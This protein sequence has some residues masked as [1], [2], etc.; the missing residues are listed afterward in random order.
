[1]EGALLGEPGK[2]ARVDAHRGVRACGDG[3]GARAVARNRLQGADRAEGERYR[4][5]CAGV[6]SAARARRDAARSAGATRVWLPRLAAARRGVLRRRAL[7][8]IQYFLARAFG[9]KMRSEERRVGKECRTGW[10]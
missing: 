6:A 2:G 1:M 9:D 5:A 10:S 7:L 4:C 8:Q 3:K